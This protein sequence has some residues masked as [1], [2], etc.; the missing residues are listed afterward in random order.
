[1]KGKLICHETTLVPVY[2][3]VDLKNSNF[4]V[5]SWK[6]TQ[7]KRHNYLSSPLHQGAM[8]TNLLPSVPLE[9]SQVKLPHEHMG[10]ISL[11]SH[12]STVRFQGNFVM[13]PIF[14]MA[15]SLSSTPTNIPPSFTH[16]NSQAPHSVSY[17]I[18]LLYSRL[19][20]VSKEHDLFVDS[21]CHY[22]KTKEA[23][24]FPSTI[25]VTWTQ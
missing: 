24:K 14:R 25:T 17:K 8:S 7:Q 4:A 3:A 2:S 6:P 23:N 18:I 9:W 12:L 13:T 10:P 16:T 11:K 21:S 15:L 5:I 19:Q 1:M 20:T 22:G